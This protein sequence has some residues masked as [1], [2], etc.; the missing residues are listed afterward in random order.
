[1]QYVGSRFLNKPNTALADGYTELSAGLGWRLA[2][3]AR[4]V[5]ATVRARW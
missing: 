4:R 1:V 5:E 2:H 3:L